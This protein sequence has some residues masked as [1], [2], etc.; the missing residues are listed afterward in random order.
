MRPFWGLCRATEG[1]GLRYGQILISLEDTV[2]CRVCGRRLAVLSGHLASEQGL[3]KGE[4]HEEF[5]QG[6]SF[7]M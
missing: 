2:E 1:A 4:Y 7:V 5:P 3:S 6:C